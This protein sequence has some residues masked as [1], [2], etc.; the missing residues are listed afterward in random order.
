MVAAVTVRENGQAEIAYVGEKPWHGLGTELR[1]GAGIEEWRKAAG[2]DWS[3]MTSPVQYNAGDQMIDMP[4]QRVLFRSDN[5][6]ALSVVSDAYKVV[7]PG[8]VL[9]FFK[10]LAD[11]NGFTIETAGTLFEG[12]RF[13]ALAAI[14]EHAVVVGDDKISG[15]LL[16]STSCDGSLTTSAKFTTVRVVCNNTLSAALKK[17][18][19]GRKV[20]VSHRSTFVAEQVKREL[21][22][23]RDSF[24]SFMRN[25]RSLAA[26]SVTT[27]QAEQFVESLL[28]DTKFVTA[29]APRR[30][31]QF[32]SVMNLFE[33]SAIGSDLPG[34]RGTAWG[35]VNAVTEYV[36]HRV[37][38]K[39]DSIRMAS[40]WFGRGDDLKNTAFERALAL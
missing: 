4:G 8:E 33:G 25:A 10:D 39:N 5:K 28:T 26:K 1:P 3:I 37:N 2:M 20:S 35:L 24:G 15:Y 40:A 12:R 29:S 11:G 18:E 19:S 36:D 31:R 17:A 32:T 34:V 38:T 13:W 14:N 22:I 30:S 16:L 21:G 7:Q 27:G 9:D 23:A 6:T